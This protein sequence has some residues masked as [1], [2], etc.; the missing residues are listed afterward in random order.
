MACI[1]VIG[2]MKPIPAEAERLVGEWPVGGEMKWL[3]I[4][5]EMRAGF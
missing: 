2:G 3:R 5:N 1:E 4:E